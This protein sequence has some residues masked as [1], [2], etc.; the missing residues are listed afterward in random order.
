MEA[1]QKANVFLGSFFIGIPFYKKLEGLKDKKAVYKKEFFGRV[2]EKC[3]EVC[4]K[5]TVMAKT[6]TV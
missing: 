4:K 6:K 2:Q 3:V 1:I 5:L